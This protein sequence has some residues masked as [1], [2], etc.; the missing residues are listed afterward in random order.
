[1][2]HIIKNKNW[3]EEEKQ[4][5]KW[6]LKMGEK[7]RKLYAKIR[8]ITQLIFFKTHKNQG[9]WNISLTQFEDAT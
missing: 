9:I 2:I 5:Q 8:K 7:T 3:S 1:M 6:K 4:W